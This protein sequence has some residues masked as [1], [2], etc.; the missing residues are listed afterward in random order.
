MTLESINPTTG[1]LIESFDEIGD[2]DLEAALGRTQQ[3]SRQIRC[4]ASIS[5]WSSGAE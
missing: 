3:A 4:I 1:E 5:S 2:A